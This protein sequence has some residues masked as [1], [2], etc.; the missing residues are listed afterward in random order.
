MTKDLTKDLSLLNSC[1][2]L[3]SLSLSNN[4]AIDFESCNALI[5]LT[6]LSVSG[7]TVESVPQKV[8]RLKLEHCLLK[9]S[10][11]YTLKDLQHLEFIDLS[12]S[13]KALS[14]LRVLYCCESLKKLVVGKEVI[15][16]LDTCSPVIE[17]WI[18]G[19]IGLKLS[20]D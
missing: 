8:V 6:D 2:A 19:L 12:G 4:D 14:E 3:R 11:L 20:G 5:N 1:T 7:A 16:D 9:A 13:I 10:L 18:E 17:G 15:S